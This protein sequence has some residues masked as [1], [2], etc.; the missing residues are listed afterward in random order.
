MS[1]LSFDPEDIRELAAILD[2]T[3]LS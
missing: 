3:G 1:R 2:E